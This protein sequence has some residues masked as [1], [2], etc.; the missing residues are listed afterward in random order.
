MNH[1]NDLQAKIRLEVVCLSG[2]PHF[3]I[4][5]SFSADLEMV[6]QRT[7]NLDQ[8]ELVFRIV[9]AKNSYTIEGTDIARLLLF[10]ST[11]VD[12]VEGKPCDESCSDC[13]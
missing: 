11:P 13:S 4:G 3:A 2:N 12:F 7:A 1:L 9:S 10:E 8:N 6:D 5:T